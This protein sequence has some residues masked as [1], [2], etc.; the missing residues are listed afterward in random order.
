MARQLAAGS[1]LLIPQPQSRETVVSLACG[2]FV[3]L[4]PIVGHSPSV[5]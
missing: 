5:A 4:R 2:D 3:A 1:E